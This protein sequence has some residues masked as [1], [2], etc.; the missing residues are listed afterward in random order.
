MDAELLADPERSI[1][2]CTT[3]AGLELFYRWFVGWARGG[4]DPI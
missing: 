3:S 1:G 2:F 4:Q